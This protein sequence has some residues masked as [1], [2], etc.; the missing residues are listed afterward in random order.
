MST[1]ENITDAI[2]QLPV[3]DV[4]RVRAWLNERAEREFVDE[5]AIDR[6]HRDAAALAA[7]DDRL[8]DHRHRLDHPGAE[9]FE[10]GRDV[11]LERGG[12]DGPQ[13]GAIRT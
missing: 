10:V 6:R 3:E 13:R 9:A 5:A 1:V 4:E 8:T 7:G 11:A 2:A 12:Q